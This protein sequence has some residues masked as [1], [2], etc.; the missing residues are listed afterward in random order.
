MRRRRLWSIRGRSGCCYDI[1]GW[2]GCMGVRA[3]FE[4]MD[5]PCVDFD[6]WV[7]V[8]DGAVSNERMEFEHALAV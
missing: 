2:I 5:C 7:C 4:G 8:H 1:G 6:A 3:A